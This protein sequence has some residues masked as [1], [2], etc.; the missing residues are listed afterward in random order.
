VIAVIG[1]RGFVGSNLSPMLGARV[2]EKGDPF[3]FDGIHT[4]IHL[5]ANA[6]VRNGWADPTR[7]LQANILLTSEVLEAMRAQKIRRL[8]FASSGSV[9]EPQ[10]GPVYRD[11]AIPETAPVHATSLY[12][13]SKIAGEQLIAA[14][15][16]AGHISATILRFVS[17]LGPHYHHGLIVDF[18]NKLKQN[19]TCLPVIGP[20]TSQ[21][22]YVHVSDVCQAIEKVIPRDPRFEVFNVGT[23]ETWTPVEIA[24]LVAASMDLVPK[25]ELTG[26]TWVGDNPY[27]LLNCWKLR[28]LGWRPGH[29]VGGAVRDT[30]DWLLR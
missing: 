4:V 21:K 28:Q 7:D 1:G 22:S 9:Y 6:D 27:I 3:D 12:A 24:G 13:A 19:S 25:V 17:V 16:A 10:T 8:I 11:G 5:A 23:D 29:S 30:V 20:G 14:Y 2:I 15:A 26:D 18:V